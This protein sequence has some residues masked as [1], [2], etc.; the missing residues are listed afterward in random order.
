MGDIVYSYLEDEALSAQLICEA[1]RDVI[2]HLP[3]LN[4]PNHES[5]MAAPRMGVK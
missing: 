3:Y 1:L 5:A 4:F 2:F